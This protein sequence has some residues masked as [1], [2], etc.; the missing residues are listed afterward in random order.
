MNVRRIKS[1]YTSSN[2][3]TRLQY[4]IFHPNGCHIKPWCCL[5]ALIVVTGVFLPFVGQVPAVALMLTFYY[6]YE[7]AGYR[8]ETL[9][10]LLHEQLG[11]WAYYLNSNFLVTRVFKRS[12]PAL[13][14]N[15]MGQNFST[16]QPV[17]W[18]H[19]FHMVLLGLG[20]NFDFQKMQ[21]PPPT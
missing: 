20:D 11:I 16:W 13:I 21:Q 14:V 8:Q 3:L 18:H 19:L 7:W 17:I 1:A 10:L 12:K 15:L 5:L 6:Y 4:W 9:D 2:L